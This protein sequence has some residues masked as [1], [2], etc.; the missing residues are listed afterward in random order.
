MD[1]SGQYRFEYLTHEGDTMFQQKF[2]AINA[3]EQ[4]FKTGLVIGTGYATA[5][6]IIRGTNRLHEAVGLSSE[7]DSPVLLNYVKDKYNALTSK[8]TS[9]T[10]VETSIKAD[11]GELEKEL[12]KAFAEPVSA[13]AP[14]AGN[15]PYG[16]I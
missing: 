1:A 13:K 15:I 16:G 9:T 12:A 14:A 2:S 11:S 5:S 7:L 3:I 4:G 10:K 8:S 6:T